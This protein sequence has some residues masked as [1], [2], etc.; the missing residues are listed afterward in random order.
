MD[1][2]QVSDT[3]IIFCSR[4]KVVRLIPKCYQN[5]LSNPFKDKS[6]QDDVSRGF[7]I[8]QKPKVIKQFILSAKVVN[9]NMDANFV[10]KSLR[11]VITT[12]ILERL[13]NFLK[14]IKVVQFQYE[15]EQLRRKLEAI[16]V[17]SAFSA[18]PDI[19]DDND[20]PEPE[21]ENVNEEDKKDDSENLGEEPLKKQQRKKQIGY[22]DSIREE[23]EK[24]LMKGKKLE[25]DVKSI[26]MSINAIGTIEDLKIWVPL[27]AKNEYSRVL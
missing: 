7:I 4:P 25:K 14:K 27:D 11:L 20:V 15:Q 18:V 13:M 3:S 6:W 1:S 24:H 21:P 16:E 5:I 12:P 9:E 17:S 26:T 23:R 19:S 2:R 10:F 8:F 22:I